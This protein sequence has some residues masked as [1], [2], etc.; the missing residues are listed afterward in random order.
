MNFDFGQ[1]EGE[2]MMFLSD[3][4]VAWTKRR[5]KAEV[6]SEPDM[7]SDKTKRRSR[8]FVRTRHDFGQY[9]GEKPRIC[10]NSV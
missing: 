6:L 4:G 2:R 1:N 8:E 9:E 5:G 10:P 7:T 3:P